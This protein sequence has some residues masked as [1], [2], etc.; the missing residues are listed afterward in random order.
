MKGQPTGQGGMT[1]RTE[2]IRGTHNLSW[3]VQGA[4]LI[5][6]DRELVLAPGG[7]KPAAELVSDFLGRPIS[8]DA[9]RARLQAGN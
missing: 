7:S 5:G 3:I 8:V 2:P 9:Y 1:T 4:A 6:K